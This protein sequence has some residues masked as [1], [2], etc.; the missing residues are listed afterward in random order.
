MAVG[1]EFQT[2]VNVFS[3]SPTLERELCDLLDNKADAQRFQKV[4]A[5]CQQAKQTKTEFRYF[6]KNTILNK[7]SLMGW[8][9]LT[10]GADLEFVTDP[11]PF[12]AADDKTL[13]L[14]GESVLR[15]RM[16]SLENW[17]ARLESVRKTRLTSPCKWVFRVD[18]PPLFNQFP[19]FVIEFELNKVVSGFPQVT[20]GIR[21]DRLR[22][23]FKILAAN[24]DS[25]T[26]KHFL[27]REEAEG[28]A[29]VLS[30][31]TQNFKAKKLLDPQ[32]PGHTP[33]R[34]LRSLLTLIAVYVTQGA[35]SAGAG[36]NAVKLL[37]FIM[38][39]TDFGKL[40]SQLPTDEQDHYRKNPKHWVRY[41]CHDVMGAVSQAVDENGKLIDRK[42][43]DYRQLKHDDRIEIPITRKEW[44]TEMTKGRDL[45]T[46]HAHPTKSWKDKKTYL[47]VH[48]EHRLRG[49]GALGDKMDHIVV[50]DLEYDGAIFE[51]RGPGTEKNDMG[52]TL[53]KDYAVKAYRFLG[54]VNTHQ[55]SE[56]IDQ[57]ALYKA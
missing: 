5:R 31:A 47:D 25:D 14:P 33:S 10:D 27:G 42:I 50:N 6:P 48:G 28:Y 35:K 44:L 7:A 54:A 21:L 30:N 57:V 37:W 55:K 36:L 8:H 4:A 45:L 3:I 11:I 29:A 52:Y 19:P 26:S 38:A 43:T 2:W 34:E 15:S 17:V 40:F 9:L 51:F 1:F 22:K 16:E 39:R 23:V 24:K 13:V 20:G 12:E 46:E 56:Q 32:W 18:D 41:I 53:W 49:S